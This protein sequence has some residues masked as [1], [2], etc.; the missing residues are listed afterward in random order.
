MSLW[1]TL[2][3]R[4][5]KNLKLPALTTING[6]YLSYCE[7]K[8][9]V[10]VLSN[11]IIKYVSSGSR[12][13]ILHSHPFYDALGILSVLAAECICIPMSLKYGESN[14]CEI[15]KNSQPH[16]IISDMISIKSTPKLS[17]V[18]EELNIKCISI[19][20]IEA[21]DYK[22]VNNN[23]SELA[24]IMHTSGT[25]GVSKGIM[26][27]H[28]NIL[29][30][31]MDISIYFKLGINDH[32]LIGRPIYHIAVMTGEF[33]Y[34]LMC[35]AR[36]SFYND[37]ISPRRIFNYINKYNCTTMCWTP[38]MFYHMAS[39]KNKIKTPTL[40]KVVISGECISP[41]VV[42][43]LVK[44]FPEADF[45]NVYGLTEASPR[46]S[47]LEPKYFRSKIGSVGKPLKSVEV[48]IVDKYGKEVINGKIGELIVS[49]PNVMLGY[50]N[51]L[52]L[53]TEKIKNGWLYTGDL[54]YKDSEDF[55]YIIGR[56][57][58]MI[59]KAGMNIY[60]QEIENKLMEEDFIIEVMAWGKKEIR[61][62]QKICLSMVL[63]NSKMDQKEIKLLCRNKLAPYQWPDEIYIVDRLEKN[64]SG[65]LLRKNH[66]N[67]LN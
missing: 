5:N 23:E 28:D 61:Y 43:K 9:K 31:L 62:G 36:I 46:V 49:G 11:T 20:N 42:D 55:L 39:N 44:A 7:L 27:S 21:N 17:N 8:D 40:K 15:I 50:W 10:T 29:S 2:S 19:N 4:F 3:E 32:I 34:A 53:T 33:L 13:V 56:K 12:V 48:R 67:N 30:N 57:D 22:N 51:N 52:K 47:Y 58:D 41:Q 37:D 25:T 16:L 24:M 1:S 26:L 45:Y 38:T 66:V 60:P 14:C 59:I 63:A 18:I 64:G 54:A 65:K 6:D 35:G